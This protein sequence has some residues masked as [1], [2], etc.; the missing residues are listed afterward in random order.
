MRIGLSLAALTNKGGIGRYLRLL[1]RGLPQYFPDHEYIAYIPG[2]REGETLEILDRESIEGWTN[3]IVPSGNRW[4]YETTGLLTSLKNNPPDVFH[5]PDYLVPK[6]PCPVFVTVHDLAFRIHSGGMAFKSRLLFSSLTPP[7]VKRASDNGE[8]FCDSQSTLDDLRKLK[9]IPADAGRVIHLACEDVFNEP[10]PTEALNT[11]VDKFKLPD[12][13]ILYVGPIEARKNIINLVKAYG[14]FSKVISRRDQ[15]IPPLVAAGPIGAG[16]DKLL[17]N[18]IDASDGLFRHI[19]YLTRDEL[20][21][22]YSG[23]L[24][25]CYPSRYEGFGLPPLEAMSAGKAV[26]V[27]DATSLPEVVGEAGILIDPD[28]I[29]QWS[30]AML[31]LYTT[32]V[33]RAEREAASIEQAKKFSIKKMCTEVME[34]YLSGTE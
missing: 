21:A 12:E 18:L 28:D 29:Q 26:I 17:R 6:A 27:S 16:G 15:E 25:F 1:A 22:L 7:S 8:I 23:C 20:R 33:E 2:F 9:W 14:I 3:A 34:G 11:L 13:Y 32:P 10:V 24:Y 19:G 4:S 5:G 30:T 31:M